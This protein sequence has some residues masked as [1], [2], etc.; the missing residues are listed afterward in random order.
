MGGKGGGNEGEGGGKN[1][2]VVVMDGERDW[3]ASQCSGG[4]GD[5]D[6]M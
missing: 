4:G 3:G 5:S 1:G 6:G 2:S